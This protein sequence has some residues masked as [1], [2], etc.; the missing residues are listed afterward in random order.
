MDNDPMAS[1][2]IAKM[3]PIP[4]DDYPKLLRYKVSEKGIFYIEDLIR[5]IYVE[6]KELSLHK[7]TQLGLLLK[8]YICQTKRIDEEILFKE[9]SDRA[10]KYGGVEKDFIK[11]VITNLTMRDLIGLNPHYDPRIAI[12]IHQKSDLQ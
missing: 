6:K 2:T 12:K 3:Y 10:K 8:T 11:K 7:L 5:E 1:R 4:L 9:I